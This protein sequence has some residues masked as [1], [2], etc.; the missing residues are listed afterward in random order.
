MTCRT[1]ARSAISGELRVDRDLPE[2]DQAT[3]PDALSKAITRLSGSPLTW[4]IRKSPSS[5]GELQQPLAMAPV[6]YSA[7]RSCCQAVLPV[8]ASSAR[9]LHCGVWR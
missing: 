4:R 9:S 2:E 3:A 1:P 8:P 7:L 6:L 5:K